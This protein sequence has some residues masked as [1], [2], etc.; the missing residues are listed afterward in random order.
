LEDP[1]HDYILKNFCVDI[2]LH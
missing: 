2:R 1:E